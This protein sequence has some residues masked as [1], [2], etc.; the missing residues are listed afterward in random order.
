[1]SYQMLRDMIGVRRNSFAFAGFLAV[2]NIALLLYLSLWQ[3]PELAKAQSEWFAQRQ[4]LASGQS[5]GSAAR[6][7]EGVRDLELFQQ[8]L[9]PKKNFAGFLSEL[10]ESAK[11]NSLS[12]KGIVYKAT[13][14]KPEGMLSYGISFTVSGKYAAVKSFIADLSRYPEMVT[15]DAVSLNSTSKTEE[16][17]NLRVQMTAYLKMEGA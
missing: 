11:S 13:P 10:F 4:A 12:M 7:Q 8:R 6:Y 1:M 5:L 17:V 15:L 16:S 2:L 3:Q 9:I 14:M